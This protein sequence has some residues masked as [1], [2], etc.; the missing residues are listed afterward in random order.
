MPASSRL[1]RQ[2]L[3]SRLNQ[4]YRR[5]LKKRI[6]FPVFIPE[7]EP[8]FEPTICENPNEAFDDFEAYNVG[9]GVELIYGC[10]WSDVGI[11]DGKLYTS[12]DDFESYDVGENPI[13]DKGEEW[14]ENAN[15][16]II[17]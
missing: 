7:P 8:G 10:G 12:I 17:Q 5:G 6:K 2:I 9:E 4:N 14:I 1:A 3:S 13:I 16:E 11:L 15:I